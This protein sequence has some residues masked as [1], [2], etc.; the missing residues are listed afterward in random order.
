MWDQLTTYLLGGLAILIP[1]LSTCHILLNKDDV[2]A[3]IG[4]MGLVWLVPG[5]GALLYMVLG[6]NRIRRRAVRERSARGLEP[7]SDGVG[8]AEDADAPPPL[9]ELVPPSLAAHARL[10]GT[11]TGNPLTAGNA[12]TPLVGGDAAYDAMLAAIDGA[13]RSVA[14]TTYIF[15]ADAAGVRFVEAL[16]DDL[17]APPADQMARVREALSLSPLPIDEIARAAEIGAARCAAILMEL[18]L[19]GE[20]E[21]LPGGLAALAV[22]LESH[23]VDQS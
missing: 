15:K 20:A 23:D 3:A 19:A 6:V 1:V 8:P 17:D 7:A 18:E 16:I 13:E 14:L 22:S 11:V 9:I 4:W 10:V 12:V 2:R 5:F 21:T